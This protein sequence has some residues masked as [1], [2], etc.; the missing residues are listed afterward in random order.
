MGVTAD[1]VSYFLST[2][3]ISV[4][5]DLKIYLRSAKADWCLPLIVCKGE[6]W[7][8]TWRVQTGVSVVCMVALELSIVGN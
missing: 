3:G 4:A 6:S 1:C 5:F 7:C 8:G 2:L